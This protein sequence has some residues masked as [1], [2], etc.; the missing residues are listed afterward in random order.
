M[1]SSRS[2][3]PRADGAS[4]PPTGPAGR[5]RRDLLKLTLLAA[6]VVAGWVAWRLP[7]ARA[8]AS[9]EHVL[10]LRDA[11][12]GSWWGPPAFVGIYA[13]LSSLDMSGLVLSTTGAAI[14]G[15]GRALVLNTVGA[16]LGANAAYWL[17]RL[18]GSDAIGSLL[19]S[20]AP[21]VHEAAERHGFL[22][23]L[24]L[25]LLP[26]VPFNLLDVTAGLSGMRWPPYAA[27]TV[28][29]MLPGTLLFTYVASRIFEVGGGSAA[30]RGLL[31]RVLGVGAALVL[32]T[33][34]PALAG[35]LTRRRE[36]R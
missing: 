16:N 9:R 21:A 35:C 6:L 7:A 23:L 15:F 32:L 18:L 8:F 30:G 4:S 12:A 13:L 31:L 26:V 36:R 11:V 24:R 17:A 2:T 10:A 14:F 33:F 1:E 3:A 19:G 20:R 29:G 27:A 28:L 34:A 25:R 22:W 5:R